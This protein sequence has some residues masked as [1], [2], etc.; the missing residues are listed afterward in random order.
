MSVKHAVLSLLALL[1]LA[2]LPT[3]FKSYGIYIFTSW[4]IFIIATMGLNLTVGYAGQKSLGHA[5]FFGT[6]AYAAGIFSKFVWG[7][8]FTGLIVGAAAAALGPTL[9]V[10]RAISSAAKT[11]L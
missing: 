11:R 5:A 8:P 1:S 4:L 10:N 6:G 3:F 2:V 9:A 7:E